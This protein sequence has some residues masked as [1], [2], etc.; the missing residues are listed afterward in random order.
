MNTNSYKHAI[1]QKC[2]LKYKQYEPNANIILLQ[3]DM[4]RIDTDFS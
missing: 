4:S 2:T 1:L 3:T